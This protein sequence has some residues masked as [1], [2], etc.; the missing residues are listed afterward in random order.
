ML[1]II[2]NKGILDEFFLIHTTCNS[3][4]F[5]FSSSCLIN[6]C[7]F[8]LVIRKEETAAICLSFADINDANVCAYLDF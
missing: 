5:S 7:C 6:S 2:V 8:S 3:N 1:E 4:D